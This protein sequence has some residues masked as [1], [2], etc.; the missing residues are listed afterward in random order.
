MFVIAGIG[1]DLADLK[2]I[3]EVLERHREG[4]IRRIFSGQEQRNHT[5][6]L[7]TPTSSRTVEFIGGRFAV[8]EAV[9][10]ALGCG[11]GTI[12]W[13]DIEVVQLPSG[14]PSVQL[15]GQALA[16]AAARKIEKWHVSISHAKDSVVAFV[17]AETKD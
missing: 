10:K 14:A 7:Q 11:I 8:K 13:H 17:V 12:G 5:A 6:F 3:R 2:R 16:L 9:S 1:V 4:F 15:T